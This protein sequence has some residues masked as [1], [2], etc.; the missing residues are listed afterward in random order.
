ME[1][2]LLQ[3]H[4]LLVV[5]NHLIRKIELGEAIW[6]GMILSFCKNEKTAIE[7]VEIRQPDIVII[8]EILLGA[9]SISFC[10]KLKNNSLTSHAFVVLI[11][12]SQGSVN[13][14]IMAG[15]DFCIPSLFELDLLPSIIKN[16]EQTRRNLVQHLKDNLHNDRPEMSLAVSKDDQMMHKINMAIELKLDDPKLNVETLSKEI[17]VSSNFLYRKVK[18]MTGQTLIDFISNYRISIGAKMLLDN[19]ITIGEVGYLVGF[20]SPSYFS[21]RFKEIY[22]CTPSQFSD[23]HQRHKQADRYSYTL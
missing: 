20:N 5:G 22:G 16:I 6:D 18:K 21:R 9:S 17:G 11:A 13:R 8:E 12:E 15:A 7:M 2:N 19:N 10:K 1:L 14:G 4:I 3:M 23:K